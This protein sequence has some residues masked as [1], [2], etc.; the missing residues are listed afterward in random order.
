MGFGC[1][2]D[3]ATSSVPALGAWCESSSQNLGLFDLIHLP[4]PKLFALVIFH[5]DCQQVLN[6]MF[7]VQLSLA[8]QDFYFSV[9]LPTFCTSSQFPA[10][11]IFHPQPF[12]LNFSTLKFVIDCIEATVLS[13]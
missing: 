2:L 10:T 9:F 8:G 5:S 13:Q 7:F 1:V 6:L 11:S 12:S 3:T 4:M